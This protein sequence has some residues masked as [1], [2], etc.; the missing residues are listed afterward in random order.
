M[1]ESIH[2][3]GVTDHSDAGRRRENAVVVA[4]MLRTDRLYRYGVVVETNM[5]PI[6]PGG[7]SFITVLFQFRKFGPRG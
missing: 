6:L 4:A 3:Q 7:G 1:G 2:E 5:D